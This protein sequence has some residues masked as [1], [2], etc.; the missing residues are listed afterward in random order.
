M[1][2]ALPFT[3]VP[4]RKHSKHMHSWEFFKEQMLNF[5]SQTFFAIWIMFL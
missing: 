1:L 3:K 2:E 4:T 5:F